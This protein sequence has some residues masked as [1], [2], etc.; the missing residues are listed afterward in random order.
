MLSLDLLSTLVLFGVVLAV[1]LAYC[2]RL[3]FKGRAQFD[4]VDK[5]G[6]SALLSKSLMEAAYWSMQPLARLLVALRISPNAI[7]WTSLVFGAISGVSLAVGHFGFGAVFATLSAAMD[8]FD[9]RVARLRGMS[10]GAGQVLDSSVDRYVE[11][12]FLGGLIVYYRDILALLILALLAMIGSF[13]VSYSTAK[14]ESLQVAPP[15]G[16]MRRPERGFYLTLGA[17]LSPIT[18]PWLETDGKFSVP[19]GHPMVMALGLVAVVANVSAIERM[20]S[21][22]RAARLR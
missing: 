17:A 8:S 21:I 14:A 5:Q 10:S 15:K 19:M 12:M 11:F 16:S 22:A 2:L 7:S 6:G 3:I 18:I 1:G 9:G 20:V 13:M 4:R